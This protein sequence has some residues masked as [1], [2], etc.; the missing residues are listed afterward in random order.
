MWFNH[1]V[2]WDTGGEGFEYGLLSYHVPGRTCSFKLS[3]PE[4]GRNTFLAYYTTQ[5]AI[6]HEE[7]RHL[8]LMSG[9]T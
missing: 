6:Q 2:L 7:Q 9:M 8:L 4:G 5:N 3:T 1:S